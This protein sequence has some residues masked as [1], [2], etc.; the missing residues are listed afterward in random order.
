MEARLM[1][2]W[3]VVMIAGLGT[4]GIRVSAVA[5]L[6]RFGPPGPRVESILRLIAPA[7]M[8]ALVA[9]QLKAGSPSGDAPWTWWVAALPT[10]AVAWKWRSAGAAIAVG[11]TA[12]VLLD[13]LA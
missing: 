7:V 2:A 12:L 13:W 10:A 1:T 11:I 9:T 8:A 3:I 6:G 4:F 5:L